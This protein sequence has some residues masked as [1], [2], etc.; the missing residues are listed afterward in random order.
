MYAGEGNVSMSPIS[1]SELLI[2]LH[3]IDC[4]GDES[5]MKAVIR[6]QYYFFD[7]LS[8]MFS[9]MFGSCVGF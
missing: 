4:R 5:L 9:L 2:A 3:N 7:L 6:G 1:P 8:C